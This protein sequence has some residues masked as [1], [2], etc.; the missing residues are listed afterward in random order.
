MNDKPLVVLLHGL[1][2]TSASMRHMSAAL[3]WGLVHPRQL[4]A[5]LTSSP[6]PDTFMPM[7]RPFFCS[8]VWRRPAVAVI[9]SVTAK[10]SW[11]K[12]YRCGC[13]MK[14]SLL[15]PPAKSCTQKRA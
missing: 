15:R 7:K 9:V 14:T 3:R 6:G 12:R 5:E 13:H 8:Q 11:P 1:A 2:R 4:L 10:L